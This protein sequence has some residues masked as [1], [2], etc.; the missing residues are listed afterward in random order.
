MLFFFCGN[1]IVF[2]TRWS[3]LHLAHASFNKLFL[4]DSSRIRS[5]WLWSMLFQSG[6]E[7]YLFDFKSL[8]NNFCFD[9]VDCIRCQ[10]Y[11]YKSFAFILVEF[12]EFV[13]GN[14]I[15]F[16]SILFNQAKT[17]MQVNLSEPRYCLTFQEVNSDTFVCLWKFYL[18]ARR[19]Y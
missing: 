3:S 9:K 2:I 4:Y 12:K 16:V 19:I 7:W 6:L 8:L 18:V 15:H 14:V 5:S 17:M 13:D 10:H 1:G 11:F